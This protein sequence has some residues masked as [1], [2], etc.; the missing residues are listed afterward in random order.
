MARL[1]R[2]VVV[3]LIMALASGCA[4]TREAADTTLRS[5]PA[6]SAPLSLRAELVR[7]ARGSWGR[8]FLIFPRGGIRRCALRVGS[9]GN[10]RVF[11][12]I[13]ETSVRLDAS[14]SHEARVRF[15]VLWQ[16]QDMQQW[17]VTERWQGNGRDRLVALVGI[18]PR[19]HPPGM[20]PNLALL[21]LHGPMS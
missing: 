9:A 3:A 2:A 21:H 18:R 10:R 17:T 5:A 1:G 11:R 19:P 4:G 12:G 15:H 7:S 8:F 16:R 13:C 20:T 6:A 14:G